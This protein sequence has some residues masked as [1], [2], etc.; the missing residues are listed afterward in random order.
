MYM[1]VSR[2]LYADDIV[3]IAESCDELQSV[4]NAMTEY[5]DI[6]KLTVN[7]TKIMVISRGKIRT[8]P[9]LYYNGD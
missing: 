5:C 8:L 3:I 9:N 7:K 1:K 6:N 4:L 2:L